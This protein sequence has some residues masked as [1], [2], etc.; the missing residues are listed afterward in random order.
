V[1]QSNGTPQIVSAGQQ[2]I[3]QK[4][5]R[6]A[7]IESDLAMFEMAKI[8]TGELLR[9]IRDSA[10]FLVAGGP[11][12]RAYADFASYCTDRWGIGERETGR[13]IEAFENVQL[14]LDA[15]VPPALAPTNPWQARDLAVLIHRTDAATAAQ[16]WQKALTDSADPKINPA[17]RITGAFLQGYVTQALNNAG[18][19]RKVG[20]S[21]ARPASTS[22]VVLNG[23]AAAFAAASAA[24]A[25]H[26]APAPV[27]VPITQPSVTP[28]SP[29]GTDVAILANIASDVKDRR[30][31]LANPLA[32][33]PLFGGLTLLVEEITA[34]MTKGAAVSAEG[35]ALQR[36]LLELSNAISEKASTPTPAPVAP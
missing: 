24:S 36:A 35:Q 25:T 16:T 32:R 9:E 5:T 7:Q 28:V 6:L 20:T 3:D 27:A 33:R 34:K 31:V 17:G 1:S 26:A 18:R 21:R 30:A 10:L 2:A 8:K 13:R 14:L 29:V 12:S 23:Q 19:G 15:G 11:G 22:T 4:R